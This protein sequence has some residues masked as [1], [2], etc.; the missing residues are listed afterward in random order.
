MSSTTLSNGGTKQLTGDCGLFQKSNL[1]TA[2]GVH[3]RTRSEPWQWGYG[4]SYTW[5]HARDIIIGP[6]TEMRSNQATPKS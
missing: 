2:R 4:D 3:G 6:A 5:I 1:Y